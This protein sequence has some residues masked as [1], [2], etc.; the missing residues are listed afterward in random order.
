[1]TGRTQAGGV[2]AGLIGAASFAT[3][4][5]MVKPLL[6][7]GWTPGAAITVRL[8]LGALLLVVPTLL[9]VRG[10]LS[11]VWAEWRVVVPFGLV[12]V[13]GGCTLFYLAVDRLSVA[14]ALLVEYTGPL[15]LIGWSWLRTRRA[16]S[17]G[18][19]LGAALAMVGLVAV[20]DVS[21]TVVLDPLGLVFASAAA[22]ANACYF[23][24]VGVPTTLPPVAT[25]GSGM[26]L[27][28]LTVGTLAAT[29]LL[30]ARVVLGDVALGGAQVS[31]LVPVLVVGLVPTAFAYA[32]S[33]ISVRLLGDRVASFVALAE[34]LFAMLLAWLL[35]AETP[36]L[37]QLVGAAVVVAGVAVVRAVAT[38][39]DVVTPPLP[40][41]ASALV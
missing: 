1:M 10:R 32:V 23:A 19:L 3:S 14:V 18:T 22:V 4:G 15:L 36:S 38:R 35:L 39:P 28:A 20:L 37:V 16:P 11:R 5:P 26:V 40:E 21:G 17:V 8:S 7:A 9:A 13:A 2:V 30:P 12:G 24:L 29:G 27:G 31:W 41:P 6:A 34:V 33:A 25:A